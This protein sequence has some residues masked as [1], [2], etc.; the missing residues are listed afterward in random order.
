MERSTLDS[1]PSWTEVPHRI[2]AGDVLPEPWESLFGP[3]RATTRSGAM[4]VGQIGQSIDGRIATLSGHS[5]YINGPAGLDHLHRLRS[6]VDAV[7]I[8]A[9]TVRTD[10]PQLTVRRV[11]GPNPARVVIDPRGTLGASA[12]VFAADGTRRIVIT[13]EGTRSRT[14]KDFE[15]V[16]LPGSRALIDPG[17][18]LDALSA[19]GLRR[20]LVEGGARTISHFLAAGCLDRLHVVVAPVIVG[21]GLPGLALP[22]VDR[23]TDALRVPIHVHLLGDEVLFDCDL[24]TLP[25]RRLVPCPRHM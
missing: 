7:I 2:R 1:G 11:S 20:V 22:P 12:R 8:G 18:I 4:V 19:R 10:D 13:L 15:T 23:M 9:G 14:S 6:L 16:A 24:G 5:H 25:Q 21:S 17:A 3:L